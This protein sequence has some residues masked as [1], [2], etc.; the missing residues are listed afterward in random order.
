MLRIEKIFPGE[1]L[2]IDPRESAFSHGMGIFESMQISNGYLQ[3]WDRHWARLK[4]SASHLFSYELSQVNQSA[5][6]EAIQMYYQAI[7][8]RDLILKLSFMVLANEPVLYIYSR[9]RI[10]DDGPA[11]LS[12]NRTHPI[13]ENSVYTGYKTHNYLENIWLL[14]EAKLAGYSDY[15]RVNTKGEVCETC[16]G[17][18]FFIKDDE[19]ITASSQTGLF[20]GVIRAVLLEALP[21]EEK[22]ISVDDLER[23][24]GCF[25]T[26]SIV[27][28]LPVSEIAG[29]PKQTVHSFSESSFSKIELIASTLKTIAQSEAINLH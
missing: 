6:L 28:I 8:K 22:Q 11:E 7:G 13:N 5:T 18:C 19:I 29:L 4:A 9:K 20:P 17:N 21:I 26:N 25:V 12:L 23:M 14:N 24:D 10:S 1:Q 27:E 16:V 2:T 3:F 15:L